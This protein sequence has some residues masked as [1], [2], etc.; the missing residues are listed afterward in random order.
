MREINI[1]GNIKQV[2]EVT[3]PDRPWN[4]PGFRTEWACVI[5]SKPA[6]YRVTYVGGSTYVCE[7]HKPRKKR[8]YTLWC[9]WC[10][11]RYKKEE[12]I[13]NRTLD[14]KKVRLCPFCRLL[15]TQLVIPEGVDEPIIDEQIDV[16]DLL[17]DEVV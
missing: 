2:L 12:Q 8:N 14:G 4:L 5:C 3:I 13:I 7:K 15:R 10:E 11:R 1:H 17:V 6:K 16:E 9:P